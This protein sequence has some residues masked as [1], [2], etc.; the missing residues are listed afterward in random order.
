MSPHTPK[1]TPY[2]FSIV[3]TFVSKRLALNRPILVLILVDFILFS[4]FHFYISTFYSLY[5][6]I[7][8]TKTPSNLYTPPY[9]RQNTPPPK[10]LNSTPLGKLRLPITTHSQFRPLLNINKNL[11]SPHRRFLRLLNGMLHSQL[12][13]NFIIIIPSMFI[14]PTSNILSNKSSKTP[15]RV[16]SHFRSTQFSQ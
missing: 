2:S 12:R 5:K 3:C 13:Q 14:K 1:S 9:I 6:I 8:S 15:S 16:N 11:T 7:S 10:S 4:Y